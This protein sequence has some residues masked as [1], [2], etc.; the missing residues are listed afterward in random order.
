MSQSQFCVTYIHQHGWTW[1]APPPS[2]CVPSFPRCLFCPLSDQC[3]TALYGC[4]NVISFSVLLICSFFPPFLSAAFPKTFIQSR[5]LAIADLLTYLCPD[6]TGLNSTSTIS[7]CYCLSD[8]MKNILLKVISHLNVC[9]LWPSHLLISSP[10]KINLW[11]YPHPLLS[12]FSEVTITHKVCPKD[13]QLSVSFSGRIKQKIT[14]VLHIRCQFLLF[15]TS[16]N[17]FDSTTLSYAL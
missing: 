8:R 3:L 11:R 4:I 7:S 13:I 6:S 15:S 17:L 12:V 9:F 5:S 1:S 2:C 14:K 10:K 16:Q